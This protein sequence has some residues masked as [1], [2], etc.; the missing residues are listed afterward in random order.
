[1][2]DKINPIDEKL[3]KIYSYYKPHLEVKIT[4]EPEELKRA[5][6]L[7]QKYYQSFQAKVCPTQKEHINGSLTP[8]QLGQKSAVDDG[9]DRFAEHLIVIDHKQNKII[10]YMRLIDANVAYKIGGYYSETQFNLNKLFS[11]NTYSYSLEMSRV[12]IDPE[13]NGQETAQL[14]WSALVGYCQING[15]DSLIGTFTLPVI[16]PVETGSIINHLKEKYSSK[17]QYQVSP[18]QILLAE[19]AEKN[20]KFCNP[21]IELFFEKGCK[22]CGDAHWNHDS[23]CAE[24]FIHY[25]LQN[26]PVIPD[27]FYMDEVDSGVNYIN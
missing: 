11:Q 25:P 26:K 6:H 24:I 16:E 7:R 10:A 17:H 23:N 21:L 9:Y 12:V 15:L 13:Y 5:K 20:I 3:K 22:L 2:M 1:M 4:K 18:Y 8:I 27:Y 14:I 19:K